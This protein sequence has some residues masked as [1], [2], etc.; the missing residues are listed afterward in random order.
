MHTNTVAE[1]CCCYLSGL[2]LP[3]RRTH[4]HTQKSQSGAVILFTTQ[5]LPPAD[6]DER[7]GEGQTAD[8]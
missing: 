1:S 7:L 4:K 8:E 2:A 5:A 3:V 6:L